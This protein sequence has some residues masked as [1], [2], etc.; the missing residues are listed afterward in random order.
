VTTEDPGRF[1]VQ[2][3]LRDVYE[4]VK[5][6]E[7]AVAQLANNAVHAENWRI[8]AD[9]DI[10]EHERKLSTCVTRRELW[11]AVLGAAS[12]V[13]ALSPFLSRVYGQ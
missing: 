9:R 4:S 10:R 6:T 8:E 5:A 13:A 3:T 7:A 1:V 2:I 11:S 12:L